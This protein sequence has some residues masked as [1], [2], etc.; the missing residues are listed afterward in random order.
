MKKLDTFEFRDDSR[1]SKVN[2]PEE[3]WS[4]EIIELEADDLH[5]TE[6]SDLAT[7]KQALKT[8]AAKRGYAIRV[9]RGKNPDGSK[10]LSLVVQAFKLDTEAAAEVDVS[11]TDSIAPQADAEV[12]DIE[13]KRRAGGRRK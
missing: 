5:V 8:L 9:N 12:V 3:I 10:A 7:R 11:E 13:P 6:P 2:Y 4:G 1:A